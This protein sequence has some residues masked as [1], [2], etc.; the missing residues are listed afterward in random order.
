[1]CSIALLLLLLNSLSA[2]TI[3]HINVTHP[4]YHRPRRGCRHAALW[5]HQYKKTYPIWF[6]TSREFTCKLPD[7]SPDGATPA[8][9]CLTV[10]M[11][12]LYF[13]LVCR[14]N[15][16]SSIHPRVTRHSQKRQSMSQVASQSLYSLIYR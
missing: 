2:R 5:T 14:V 12:V 4:P 8:I 15:D 7:T 13:K 9:S 10:F 11:F 6:D 1:M 16:S 3:Y